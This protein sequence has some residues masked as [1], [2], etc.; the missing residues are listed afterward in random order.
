MKTSELIKDQQKFWDILRQPYK[1]K[2][3]N[4]KYHEPDPT[5]LNFSG[6]G[7]KMVDMVSNMSSM[8]YCRT[9]ISES[10]SIPSDLLGDKDYWEWDGKTN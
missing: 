2:C 8:W 3:L 1:K 10:G 9:H 5:N 6:W 4:C 7:C